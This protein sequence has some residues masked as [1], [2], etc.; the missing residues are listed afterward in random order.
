MRA[1]ASGI[2]QTLRE[3]HLLP[4]AGRLGPME[5]LAS[6]H[7]ASVASSGTG[8]G[9][10]GMG[11]FPPTRIGT[12]PKLW[13]VALEPGLTAAPPAPHACAQSPLAL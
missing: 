1:E 13:T 8:R 10:E 3:P 6:I 2:G 12:A 7:S 5:H 9:D 4:R 11:E